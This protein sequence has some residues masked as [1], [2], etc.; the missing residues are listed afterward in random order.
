MK[1]NVFRVLVFIER[2]MWLA[3]WT[4]RKW[5]VVIAMR[6]EC[7]PETS[8]SLASP[9]RMGSRCAPRGS[10]AWRPGNDSGGRTRRVGDGLGSVKRGTARWGKA[11]G[12]GEGMR[13]WDGRKQE[14]ESVL[15]TDN[16]FRF[17]RSLLLPSPT[18]RALTPPRS[19]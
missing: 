17:L 10:V 16:G 11:V 18:Q 9:S 6:G 3:N 2:E 5:F 15:R 13:R 19:S 4:R 12:R 7:R 1:A 14:E 8:P